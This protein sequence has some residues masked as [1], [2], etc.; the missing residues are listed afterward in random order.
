[1]RAL[2]PIPFSFNPAFIH[3]LPKRSSS[4]AV[5]SNQGLIHIMDTSHLSAPNEFHQVCHSE[6]TIICLISWFLIVECY[7]LCHINVDIANWNI[8]GPGGRRWRDPSPV[9]S[10]R[11]YAFQWLW[12]SIYNMD[13]RS[14]GTPRNWVDRFNV[15][16]LSHSLDS[17]HAISVLWTPSGAHT[18]IPSCFQLGPLS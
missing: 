16:S 11:R 9:A 12:R 13:W 14:I 3:V 5:V 8:Y 1:M 18:L 4:I 17:A 2:P 15:G 7:L 10:R 6:P